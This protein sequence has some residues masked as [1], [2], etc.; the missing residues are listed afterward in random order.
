MCLF[1]VTNV[2]VAGNSYEVK[3]REDEAALR[4]ARIQHLMSEA[5]VAEEKFNS[6]TAKWEKISSY[7]DPLDL[8][9]ET[10]QQ[11]GKLLNE[12]L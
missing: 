7:N 2:R 10:E 9:E 4:E 3:R 1:Q 12:V 11:K 8:Y 6:L 5:T